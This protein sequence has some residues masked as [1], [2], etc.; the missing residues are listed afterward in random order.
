[1][2]QTKTVKL[3]WLAPS[4]GTERNNNSTIGTGQAELETA[5]AGQWVSFECNAAGQPRPRVRWYRLA[6]AGGAFKQQQKLAQT[7]AGAAAMRSLIQHQAA[8][9]TTNNE[10][11][12]IGLHNNNNLHNLRSNNNHHHHHQLLQLDESQIR[13]ALLQL[14]ANP[15]LGDSIHRV[16]LT[17]AGAGAGGELL[18]Q[19]WCLDGLNGRLNG[20]ST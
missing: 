2:Q 8:A 18:S 12:T 11:L 19:K 4:R 14:D 6:P 5:R 9:L 10:Q 13:S 17:A 15:A 7:G 20:H 3:K 1:M 16:E